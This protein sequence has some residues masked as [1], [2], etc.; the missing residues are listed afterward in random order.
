MHGNLICASNTTAYQPELARKLPQASSIDQQT[1]CTLS[2]SFGLAVHVPRA[3][4][5][6]S[7]TNSAGL[8]HCVFVLQSFA[9]SLAL[10]GESDDGMVQTCEAAKDQAA[11]LSILFYTRKIV[12]EYGV[13]RKQ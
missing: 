2:A 4:Q 1:G 5:C 13:P 11:V 6:T 12:E 9:F 3:L 10:A 7:Y 8:K